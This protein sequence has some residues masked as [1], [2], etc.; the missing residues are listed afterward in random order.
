MIISEPKIVF[1]N[2]CE[3]CRL[4]F[5]DDS[6][7]ELFPDILVWELKPKVY[8]LARAEHTFP[9]SIHSSIPDVVNAALERR[10]ED[11]RIARALDVTN[12]FYSEN[13]SYNDGNNTYETTITLLLD[14]AK[15]TIEMREKF[16]IA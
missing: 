11:V 13:I 15:N 3:N 2:L 7:I 5:N 8:G 4:T 12:D 9:L 1:K 10:L 14:A 16:T 6:S